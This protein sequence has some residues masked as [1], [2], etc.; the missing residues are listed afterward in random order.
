MT[1]PGK[2]QSYMAAGKPVIGAINGETAKVI[3]DAGCGFCGAAE[4]AAALA[5][6]MLRFAGSD[7]KAQMGARARSW[8]EEHFSQRRFMDE[9]EREL[10]EAAQQGRE[11]QHG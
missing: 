6:N 11:P 5:E 1:L 2:V 7:Q 8:Y 3:A 9:L 10:L 4:D